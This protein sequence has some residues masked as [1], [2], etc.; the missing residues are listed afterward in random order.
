MVCLF[1]VMLP[2]ALRNNASHL[3][4]GRRNDARSFHASDRRRQEAKRAGTDNA[5]K[6]RM[7]RESLRLC[8]RLL[9]L[10]AAVDS[11]GEGGED[12][13]VRI[14]APLTAELP[15]SVRA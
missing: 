9:R 10:A 12:C 7:V 14:G 2:A 8:H 13:S 4:T 1:E 5:G 11:G 3:Q 15:N 6:G